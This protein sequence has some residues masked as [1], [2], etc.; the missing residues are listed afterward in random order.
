MLI[1]KKSSY[2]NQMSMYITN[3]IKFLDKAGYNQN[4]EIVKTALKFG[5]LMDQELC[6]ANEE[7][8]NGYC[9]IPETEDKDAVTSKKKK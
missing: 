5:K 1:S 2:L 9:I 4:D 7:E 3:C 6:K 8:R